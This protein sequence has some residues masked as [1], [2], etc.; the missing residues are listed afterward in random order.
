[1]RTKLSWKSE[2]EELAVEEEEKGGEEEEDKTKSG[3]FLVEYCF[4]DRFYLTLAGLDDKTSSSRLSYLS[5]DFSNFPYN[6]YN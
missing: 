3:E 2:G 6:H 4:D 5:K 1:M